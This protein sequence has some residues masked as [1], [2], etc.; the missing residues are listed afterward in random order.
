MYRDNVQGCVCMGV[1]GDRQSAMGRN[2][3]LQTKAATCT[4]KSTRGVEVLDV[5]VF[6]SRV[7]TIRFI[8]YDFIIYD[9]VRP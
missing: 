1:V 9:S 3:Q 6:L 4:I 2:N 5:C 7:H 8:I